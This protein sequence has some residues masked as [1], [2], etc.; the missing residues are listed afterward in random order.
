MSTETPGRDEERLAGELAALLRLVDPVP[1]E[2]VEAA[3]GSLGWRTLESELARLT[4][5][6]LLA[7]ADVRGEQARLLTYQAGE[8]TIEIEVSDAGGRLRI[9]GQLVPA[10]PARVRADQPTGGR[11]VDVDSLGRFAIRDLPAGPTRFTCQPLG[12]DGE[13]AGAEIH[14]EWLVL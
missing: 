10:E 4:A 12:P 8:R 7:G 6:S 1:A 3:R 2:V 13:P 14:S 9:L 5:D 11:E